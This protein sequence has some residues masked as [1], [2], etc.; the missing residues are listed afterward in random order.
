MT[1]FQG[2]IKS[3]VGCLQKSSKDDSYSVYRRLRPGGG[4]KYCNQISVYPH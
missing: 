1:M 2:N 4:K 3:H